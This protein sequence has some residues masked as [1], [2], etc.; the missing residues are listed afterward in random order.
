M[1][2]ENQ[3][4]TGR[5]FHKY[6]NPERSIDAG[7]TA[8]HGIKDSDVAKAPTFGEIVGEFMD[9]VNGGR[10]VIHNAEFDVKFLN[11]EIKPYGYPPFKLNETVDTLLL[12]R[13]KFPGS[14]ANLDALCRRFGIDLSERTLHG[15]LLDARLLAEVYIE[16]M[17]GRQQG[18]V[19]EAEG[20]AGQNSDIL[21]PHIA[22]SSSRTP[23]VIMATEAELEKHKDLLKQIKNPLWEQLG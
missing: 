17:G 15:A 23:R 2:V 10:L 13:Q 19:L 3:I 5:T 6:I 21:T 8:V 20:S 11:A 14:P 22:V 16:L 12:A 18:L 7:A 1:E 9:F 4:P